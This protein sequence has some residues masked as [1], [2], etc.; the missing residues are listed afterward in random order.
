[1]IRMRNIYLF[2]LLL[3]LS[4]C[5]DYYAPDLTKYEN[6]LV[7]DGLLTNGKGPYKV[8]L[9]TASNLYHPTPIP[10]S[11]ASVS[12]LDDIGNEY[13]FTESTKG[14]YLSNDPTF[15]GITGRYYQVVIVTPD[16]IHIESAPELLREPVAID[17]VYAELEYHEN[18]DKDAVYPGYQFYTNL[19]WNPVDTNYIYW[20]M[21][22]TFKFQTTFP[23]YYYYA[24]DFYPF[25][26]PDSLR[27]CWKTVVFPQPFTINTQDF[28]TPKITRHPLHFIDTRDRTLSIR[29]SVLVEQLT[30]SEKAHRYWKELQDQ[31]EQQGSL[32]SEQPYQIKGN[33]VNTDNPDELVMGYFTVAGIDTTRMFLDRPDVEF[34]YSDCELSEGDYRDVAYIRY[35][36]HTRWPFY[37][38]VDKNGAMAMP[39]PEC[40]DCRLR[41]G[42]IFMPSFWITKK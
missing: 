22:S 30:I 12:V 24:G 39:T 19:A 17:T 35:Y 9:S 25:E 31:N 40:C 14:E 33:L 2:V 29:Y 7:V 36:S 16:G 38:T 15:T 11:G 23:I 28:N 34:Y 26:D 1:M 42:T 5:I 6:S 20:R 8:H 37:L 32:Y 3:T 27:N 21:T 4:A 10:Y 41:G 18:K 13:L